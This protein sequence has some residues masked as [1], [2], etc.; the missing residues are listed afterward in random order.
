MIISMTGFGVVSLEN[1]QLSIFAEVKSLNSKF[2]DVN[3]RLPRNF[4]AE[5]EL[6]LRNCLKEKLIRGKVA[7]TVDF[8]VKDDLKPAVQINGDLL[9]YYYNQLS[10]IAADLNSEEKDLF[11]LAMM[12]PDVAVQE[13]KTD[14]FNEQYWENIK[15]AFSK[16]LDKCMEFRKDEGKELKEGLI[17]Y[18]SNIAKLLERINQSDAQRIAMI[19]EK[20]ENK[21]REIAGNELFNKDR[22]EQEMIYYLEKLD[23]SEEKLRLQSHLDYFIKTLDLP[24]ESGKKLNFISQEMGREINTIGSKANDA[25]VQKLV[26]EMKDELEKIKEQLN[27]IL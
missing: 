18:V 1:E 21:I 6:E 5:K 19:R 22:F 24:E 2:L 14:E 15:A 9:K 26:V 23:I 10:K 16:A 3:F 7:A 8:Q 12:M 4:P 25:G 27:N 20:V 17:L 11:R 13:M